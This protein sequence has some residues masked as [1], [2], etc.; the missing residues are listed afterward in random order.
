M[1]GTAAAANVQAM[2]SSPL[3]PTRRRVLAVLAGA[4]AV[5]GVATAP[6]AA[7][8]LAYVKDGNVFLTTSDGSRH[9]QVT[10]DGGYA[11]VS[12]ADNG[13]M[14][15]L[16]G[17]SIVHLERDGRVIASIKT[18][19]STSTDPNMQFKGPFDPQISPDGK[20]VAYSYYWQYIGQDP[21]CN[22]SNGCYTKRLYHGTAY[23]DPNRLTAWDEP[24]M[25]RRSGWVHPAWIDNSRVLLSEPYML[26]NEDVVF[27]TPDEHD[28][29]T[30]W[31]VDHEYYGSI[32]HA[33]MSRDLSALATIG[34]DGKNLNINRTA[35]RFHPQ[36]PERC[37]QAKA[38]GDEKLT[39][40]SFNADGTRLFWGE[41]A[42]IKAVTLPKFSFESCGTLTDGG[43]ILVAGAS[44][45]SWGPA[46]VPPAR[47]AADPKPDTQGPKGG[48]NQQGPGPDK[49]GNAGSTPKLTVSSAKLRTALKRGLTVRLAGAKAGKHGLT[50]RAGKVKVAQGNA[51]VAT[52]GSGKATLR[53]SK[54]GKRHLAGKS[55][56]KLTV[57]GAGATLKVTLR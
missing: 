51:T 9:Y 17:D 10:S 18:P 6:A 47:Q 21:Y 22:P 34:E 7:D 41:K 1:T 31:F 44:S 37:F 25:H 55:K 46:D 33:A 53:F 43:G 35:G 32:G 49:G 14:A 19:V 20:R 52:D 48:G 38:E 30:R 39:D 15:A 26:P 36:F 40:P 42:G 27:H 2:H 50:V 8:S 24:G 29:L 11:S 45:P 13:R 4:A 5:L 3:L 54:A 16:K 28:S 57:T 23:T 56:A 12:Q